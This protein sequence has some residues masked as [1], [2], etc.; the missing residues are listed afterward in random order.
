MPPLWR[1]LRRL[2]G[3]TAAPRPAPEGRSRAADGN[4]CD[5]NPRP[6][7]VPRRPPADHWDSRETAEK[8]WK[9]KQSATDK[10]TES[11]QAIAPSEA[12][13]ETRCESVSALY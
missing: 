6:G 11:P 13:S 7:W 12:T 2:A 1:A 8:C 4:G 5:G 10:A 9:D 3:S